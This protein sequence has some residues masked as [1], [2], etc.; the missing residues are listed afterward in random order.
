M[1][2]AG[3]LAALLLTPWLAAPAGL[4][5][6]ATATALVVTFRAAGVTALRAAH[7]RGRLVE[8]TLIIGAD[9]R[10]AQL[11]ALLAEHPELGLRP[12]GFLDGT[13]STT[14]APFP[15]LGEVT[16]LA[17]VVHEQGVTRV[18]V[19][20]P[21][22]EDAHLVSLLRVASGLSVDVCLVP[23][24]PE[25]GAGMPHGYLDEVWG[26]PV[27][28]LRGQR[29]VARVLTAAAH[30]V[31]A[32][33]LL[34]LTGPLLLVLAAAVR[35]TEGGPVLF[36]QTRAVGT[37]RLATVR[38]LR[39]MA[40]HADSDTR[41]AVSPAD[42]TR[43]GGWLRTT[44]LDE[45]PQLVNVLRGEMALVGPRP[46]RPRFATAFARELPHYDD[47]HR[48]RAGMTGWAQVH[49]LHGDS[50]IADRARFDNQYIEY[51]SPWMDVVILGRTVAAVLRGAVPAR[52]GGHR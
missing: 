18:L 13:P 39:T 40:E 16:E 8:A 23:R 11:A 44:H 42:C 29:R 2:A 27:V 3:A 12:C 37:G 33:A 47:R 22:V 19:A 52:R 25:F 6:A 48:V 10:G 51:W 41:W 21:A 5:L 9:Q 14:G 17:R 4:T 50:S 30:R 38:K 26:V 43:L 28:P 1:A 34:V 32:A 20:H 46:E 35:L 36:R 24:L 7:R 49:G 15:V 31:A 45:L